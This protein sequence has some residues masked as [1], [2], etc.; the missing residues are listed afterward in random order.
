MDKVEFVKAYEQWKNFLD[1]SPER[2]QREL[3]FEQQDKRIDYLLSEIEN[4][5]QEVDNR[6]VTQILQGEFDFL[7]EEEDDFKEAEND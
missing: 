7:I 3:E 6:Y 1:S 4:P 5:D 2:F